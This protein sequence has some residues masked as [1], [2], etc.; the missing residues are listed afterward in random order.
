MTEHVT[1]GCGP[2]IPRPADTAQEGVRSVRIS[3]ETYE[4][5]FDA[6]MYRLAGMMHAGTSQ[7]ECCVWAIELQKAADL[8]RKLAGWK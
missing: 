6:Q 5:E 3:R 7:Y 4:V 2:G 8:A 1:S